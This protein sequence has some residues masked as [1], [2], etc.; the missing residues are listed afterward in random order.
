MLST[1]ISSIYNLILRFPNALSDDNSLM[2]L[3]G[4]VYH[5]SFCYVLRLM[6]AIL[7]EFPVKRK[8]VMNFLAFNA[9]Q[10]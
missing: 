8:K 4:L 3:L 5:V 2:N 1:C 9:G 10:G 6:F 7:L